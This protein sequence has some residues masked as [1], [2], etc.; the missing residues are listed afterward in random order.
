VEATFHRDDGNAF[1]VPHEQAA[2]VTGCSGTREVWNFGIGNV[3]V[4]LDPPCESSQARTK[5]QPGPRLVGPAIGKE[6][7]GILNFIP[8]SEHLRVRRKCEKKGTSF[9]E[10]PV[11]WDWPQQRDGARKIGKRLLEVVVFAFE[12][13][14]VVIIEIIVVIIIKVIVFEVFVIFEVVVFD[15]FIVVE[16]IFVIIVNFFVAEVFIEAV[17]VF[18]AT[19]HRR[20]DAGSGSKQEPGIRVFV[21]AEGIKSEKH[22][23]HLI[24]DV[25]S[26]MFWGDPREFVRVIIAHVSSCQPREFQAATQ[27]CRLFI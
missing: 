9:R 4:N 20:F 7:A 10:V 25:L 24:E 1:K 19:K 21:E 17:F 8:Y 2:G 15:F 26:D 14:F 16:V 11:E 6:L 27:F 18:I 23:C 13:F 12:F 3:A 5:N 22:A